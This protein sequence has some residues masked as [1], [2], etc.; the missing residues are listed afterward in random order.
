MARSIFVSYNF[1]DREIANALP[2]VQ[3]NFLQLA[4]GKF[5]FVTAEVAQRGDAAVAEEIR[6]LLES[7]DA[8]I[9]L[10]GD[11]SPL[12]ER[13]AELAIA[14]G[15]P[16]LGARI[17]GSTAATQ[18][19]LRYWKRYRETDLRPGPLDEVLNG[20]AKRL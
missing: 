18:A 9:F 8:A 11:S 6:R 10:I 14:R 20:L 1:N 13:E 4:C 12:I 5:L 3:R 2:T 17:K 19:R 7:C 16:I 15:L